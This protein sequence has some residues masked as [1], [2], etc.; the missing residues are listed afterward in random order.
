MAAEFAAHRGEHL[1]GELSG[2]SRLEPFVR[3]VVMTGAGTPSS[4]EASTV[5]R[6]SSA[7]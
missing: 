3:D 7:R 5:H 2:P 6:P 4:T 1:V